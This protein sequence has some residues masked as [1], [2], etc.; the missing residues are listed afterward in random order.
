MSAGNF[1]IVDGL[2][3][4]DD[5]VRQALVFNGLGGRGPPV[6][7]LSVSLVLRASLISTKPPHAKS[8]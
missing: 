8:L 7:E 5:L 6:A 1:G 3:R 4:L 2:E